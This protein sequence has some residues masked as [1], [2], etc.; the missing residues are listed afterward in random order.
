MFVGG[1]KNPNIRVNVMDSMVKR[2]AEAKKIKNEIDYLS[3]DQLRIKA[4]IVRMRI[5]EQNK[6]K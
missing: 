5:K 4:E 2:L 1:I 6:I 3:R